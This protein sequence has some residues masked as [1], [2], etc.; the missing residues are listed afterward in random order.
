MWTE[1]NEGCNHMTCAECKYQWCWLCGGKYSYNHFYEGKCNGLQFFKPKSEK[2]IEEALAKNT[3]NTNKNNLSNNNRYNFRY[4]NPILLPT[5]HILVR[6]TSWKEPRGLITFRYYDPYNHIDPDNPLN[7]YNNLG[8]FGKFIHTILFLFGSFNIIG[9]RYF[10]DKIFP[11]QHR[12]QSSLQN[13]F[14]LI[15]LFIIP[16]FMIFNFGVN[17]IIL[18][19]TFFY[20]PYLKKIWI[21]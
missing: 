4:Y 12:C 20:Y 18:I 2:D 14:L 16:T 21:I 17:I 15:L 9:L 10:E 1:K 11:M 6:R 5:E 3:N 13:F 19:F 7:A 8:F